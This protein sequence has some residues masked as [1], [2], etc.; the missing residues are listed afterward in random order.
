VFG[1][2][3]CGFLGVSVVSCSGVWWF[4]VVRRFD[5]ERA[6]PL[7]KLVHEALVANTSAQATAAVPGPGWRSSLSPVCSIYCGLG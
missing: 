3:D 1:G 6:E 5:P 2:A 7:Y 4:L